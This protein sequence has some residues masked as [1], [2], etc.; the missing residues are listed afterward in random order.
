M[1]T[2]K[3][4]TA[5]TVLRESFDFCAKP[6]HLSH[7]AILKEVGLSWA[8]AIGSRVNRLI[9]KMCARIARLLVTVNADT[10]LE[11]M[12]Q[13]AVEDMAVLL[14]NAQHV[15]AL[16]SVGFVMVLG[17]GPQRTNR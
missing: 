11:A 3:A 15:T 10:A 13:S 17:L 16:L 14:R 8:G 7:A 1:F 4:N 9:L 6:V 2:V 12:S 5:I